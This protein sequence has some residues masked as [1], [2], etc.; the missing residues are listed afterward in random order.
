R[1]RRE[2]A[3][4]EFVRVMEANVRA[5]G[6]EGF[7]LGAD[8]ALEFRGGI[9]VPKVEALQKEILSEAHTAPY[10]AHPGST[11]M[12]H[13][14]KGSFWWRGMKKDVA[15]FVRR[16]LTCQQVKTKLHSP[17]GLLQP[18]PI[19][20]WKWEEV[21]MDFVTGLPKSS[22]HHDAIWVVV[23]RLTKVAHFLPVSMKMSLDK[24]AEI[25]T[26]GIIRLHGV[27]VTIVSD[28]DP[29]FISRFWHSLHEAM[30]T[31]LEFSSAYHL[32]TDVNNNNNKEDQYKP[33]KKNNNSNNPH[34]N[35]VL[36]LD[37][38]TSIDEDPVSFSQAINSDES[39]KWI[40]AMKE[41]LNSMAKNNVWDLVELPESS[42]RVGCK[43]VFKTKRDSSGNIERH[44]ARLVAKGY[45]QKDGIDYKQTFS[46]VS[47][48]DSLRIIMAL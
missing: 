2:Q 38:D 39:H 7:Q 43:W 44:K 36:Q 5:G 20:R 33:G 29:R 21:T 14:L 46:P 26:R 13:D 45:T 19:P 27:P 4:D 30:G 35:G 17:I 3:S 32:E 10:L 11:K 40:D 25:Y 23:D 28:R 8:G 16:C 31:K 37:Y 22:E 12:Y 42:K 24:L 15:E 34:P 1:I 18:L 48:K 6:V 41:E 9:V 47:E